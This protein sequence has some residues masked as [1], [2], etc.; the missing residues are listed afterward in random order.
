MNKIIT[1]IAL[2]LACISSLTF[3]AEKVML[4]K[5]DKH[6]INVSENIRTNKSSNIRDLNNIF[7]F[8]NTVSLEQRK[9]ITS[10]KGKVTT[11][12]IQKFKNIPIIGSEVIIAKRANAS[13]QQVYGTALYQIENDIKD[14]NAKLS[15]KD[16]EKIAKSIFSKQL[17]KQNKNFV[18]AK[19][20]E[21]PT[22][23]KI[24]QDTK[25]VAKLIYVVA[26]IYKG[27]TPSMPHYYIDAN[28]GVILKAYDNLMHAQATGPGGNIKTGRYE[29]GV[30]YDYLDVT[31]VDS[32]C[33]LENVNV[34][35]VDLNHGTNAQ[36][37][38]PASFSFVCPENTYKE[39]NG[40][41][42][43]LNDAHYFGGVVFNMYNDWFSTAP[44]TFQLVMQ[45]HYQS[46]YE[47]AF[48]DGARMTFGDGLNTFYPLVDLNVVSHEVSHGF[49]GQNSNLTYA[50]KSGGLNESF[51]DMAGEAAEYYVKGTNDWF[52]GA[53]I[54]KNGPGL[55]SLSDPTSIGSSI[56]HQDDYVDGMDVH[57]SS[58][59][60]NKAFYLLSTTAGWN[61]RKAFEVYVK[62]NQ[63]YW[64]SATDWNDAGVGVLNAATDLGYNLTEVCT[65]LNAV[66]VTPQVASCPVGPPPP[67]ATYT[68]IN[69]DGAWTSSS[70]GSR[71]REG[72]YAAYETFTLTR[73]TNVTINL[74]GSVD[75]Y[76]Y[77]LDSED[78]VIQA[79]DDGGSGLNSK[80]VRS[81]DAGTYIIE[82]TTYNQSTEGTFNINA[83][84]EGNAP[85]TA[86]PSVITYLLF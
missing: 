40:A 52:V 7:G 23:L 33:T 37:P 29:F 63:E 24:W 9:T 11:R 68:I 66:G 75:T 4:E 6:Q 47:N 80:I 32:N 77:L 54:I 58:G 42:S 59:V 5:T 15:I 85:V 65:S 43:P 17:L 12:Y 28:T 16:A 13:G 1:K 81:L 70:E 72:N 25:G 79:D 18:S 53:E 36:L 10:P 34:R 74:T 56:D 30:E 57:Y 3:A 39:I 35:T 71:H 84:G 48:W 22:T 38:S 78:N 86:L 2:S 73:E 67:P 49:T 31:Q 82:S 27:D 21:K 20:E 44:L 55:R 19:I 61:T 46:N 60:Y 64:T 69:V 83:V 26:F 45:V 14:V 62:A 76:L 51:S 41:Y 50:G 8:S